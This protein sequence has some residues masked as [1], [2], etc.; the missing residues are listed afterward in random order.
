[1]YKNLDDIDLASVLKQFKCSKEET[2]IPQMLMDERDRDGFTYITKAGVNVFCEMDKLFLAANTQ[3]A[4]LFFAW[5]KLCL[6]YHHIQKIHSF[7]I[8]LLGKFKKL[9]CII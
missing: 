7:W 3:S 9:G 4:G 8:K 1:V 2:N 5:M 6:K